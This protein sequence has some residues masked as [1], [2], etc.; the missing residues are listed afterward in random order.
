MPDIPGRFPL[1]PMQEGMI[2]DSMAW[3]SSA[4]SGH[5][6][7][8]RYLSLI[9][10]RLPR[11]CDS[12]DLRR[13]WHGLA[14]IHPALRTRFFLD[15]DGNLTQ[16]F[17]KDHLPGFRCQD[18]SG[19]SAEDQ[20]RAI[21]D[22][23]ETV[24]T[25]GIDPFA[26]PLCRLVLFDRAGGQGAGIRDMGIIFHHA[27]LDGWSLS[28]LMTQLLTQEAP[29][30]KG[31]PFSRYLRFLSKRDIQS[32]LAYWQARLKGVG[33]ACRLPGQVTG[34]ISDQGTDN[35]PSDPAHHRFSLGEST[36]LYGLARQL[37]ISPGR[38]L[39]ALWALLLCRYNGGQAVFGHVITG[40]MGTVPGVMGM[41][42]MCVNTIPARLDLPEEKAFSDWI[43]EWNTQVSTD[44][45]HGF[46][47]PTALNKIMPNY[48]DLLFV[49][50]P[51]PP[52][53]GPEWVRG[54]G[55]AVAGFTAGFELGETIQACFSYDSRKYPARAVARTASHFCNILATVIG[56]PD[57]GLKDISFFPDEEAALLLSGDPPLPEAGKTLVT[58]W[59]KAA[60]AHSERT[61]LVWGSTRMTYKELA[62]RV[63]ALA[64]ALADQGVAPDDLVAFTLN[65]SHRI[66]IAALAILQAGAAYLPL[67]P[68]WP[69][70]RIR[71]ILA[72]THPALML[73]DD[74][75]DRL[76]HVP[77]T[78][79]KEMPSPSD[80]PE[81]PAYIIMTSGTTGRPKGV[82]VE[83]RNAV[84]FCTW[85][86]DRY[87][88]GPGMSAAIQTEFA[89]DVAIWGLYPA[90]FSG[91][92]VHILEQEIRHTLHRIRDYMVRENITHM[93]LPVAMAEEF[94]DRFPGTKAPPSLRFLATG[95]DAVSRYTGV[96]YTVVNEYGPTECTV[97]CTSYTLSRDVTPIPIGRPL[98]GMQALI[99]DRMGRLAP[100]GVPGELC[101][102][103]VQV[104]RGYLGDDR[105]TTEKFTENPFFDPD[106]DGPE[107]RRLY[108]TGDLAC[109]QAA[110]D[111]D[112]GDLIFLG[113]MD[114]Q[115]KVRGFR[116]ELGEIESV[117]RSHPGID[118]AVAALWAP[119]SGS[120]KRLTAWVV[121][122]SR[123]FQKEEILAFLSEKLPSHMVPALIR[124]DALPLTPGGKIDLRALPAP[125][126]RTKDLTDAPPDTLAEKKLMAVLADLLPGIE[127]NV[128]L[129]FL[130]AGG[131]SINAI[132]LA[133]RLESLGW[134]VSLR[135]IMASPTLRTLAEKMKAS[136]ANTAK[137]KPVP[138]PNA[139]FSRAMEAAWGKGTIVLP[140]T[141]TQKMLLTQAAMSGPEAYA[142]TG[143]YRLPNT[144]PSPEEIRNRLVSALERHEI[145]RAGFA[146]D[147]DGG[148]WMVVPPRMEIPFVYHDDGRPED[149]RSRLLDRLAKMK[150]GLDP[151]KP[152][153]IRLEIFRVAQ[154]HLE[155]LLHYH[156]LILDGWSLGILFDEL[157]GIEPTKPSQI[158]CFGEY[159]Q[160]IHARISRHE[161]S[162]GF[163]DEKFPA[164]ARP[165]DLPVL[166]DQEAA[167]AEPDGS[168]LIQ[169]LPL[170]SPDE[171][172]AC[173]AAARKAGVTPAAFFMAM[174]VLV[175]K[176]Y[177]GCPEQEPMMLG[178]VSA[179]RPPLPG[180]ESLVGMCAR[181][182]PLAIPLTGDQSFTGFALAVQDEMDQVQARYDVPDT[183]AGRLPRHL[184]SFEAVGED[185]GHFPRPLSAHGSDGYDL[186][187]LF[188]D[189]G[190]D[191]A[192]GFR[193][194]SQAVPPALADRLRVQF[195][196]MA[197]RVLKTPDLPAGVIS[198]L[199]AEEIRQLTEQLG[200][201]KHLA[202]DFPTA[203]HAFRAAAKRYPDLPALARDTVCLTY[204]QLDDRT[205]ELARRL[206]AMGAARGGVVGAVM[207]RS[208]SGGAVPLGIMKAGAAYLPLAPDWPV[209]RINDMLAFTNACALVTDCLAPAD[210]PLPALILTEHFDA[211]E[212]EGE[213]PLLPEP[214]PADLAYVICT[215]GTTGRPKATAV[216]HKALANQV[217]WTL[218]RFGPCAHDQVL[219]A[220]AFSFDPSLWLLFPFWAS[221]ACVHMATGDL[222][223]DSAALMAALHRFGITHLALPTR[224]GDLLFDHAQRVSTGKDTGRSGFP[225]SLV[226][227]TVGGESPQ[228]LMPVDFEVINAYGPTEAC[229]QVATCRVSTLSGASRI[230]GRPLA[231]VQVYVV[232]AGIG[233]CPTGVA[234]ELCV[235]GPQLA[236][237]YLGMPGE[238][239]R[240]FLDNPFSDNPG[241][242]RIYRTGDRVRWLP[243][244]NLEF[245]GRTDDQVKIRGYR[246]ELEEVR[247]V[248]IDAPG[249]R[250][251]HILAQKDRA[252]QPSRLD[253]YY[254]PQDPP[255]TRDQIKAF[256]GSRLPAYMVPSSFTAVRH[257]PLNAHGKLDRN[258]LP[259]PLLET[260]S[261]TPPQTEAEKVL[262]RSW[263][264]V[265]GISD[266]CREDSFFDLGGHSLQLLKVMGHMAG[267]YF[268]EIQDFFKTPQLSDL[269]ARMRPVEA[270]V[271]HEENMR[272]YP[273]RQTGHHQNAGED[274]HYQ[275]LVAAAP[276]LSK[277]PPLP[278]HRIMITGA[279]GYLGAFLLK[280]YQDR[281]AATILVP[282]RGEKNPRDRLHAS[283]AFYFGRTEADRLLDPKRIIPVKADLSRSRDV[284]ALETC[285]PGLDMILHSAAAVNHYGNPEL[286]TAANV[287]ATEHLLA[288]AARYDHCRFA[289][290]STLSA[291][292]LPGFSELTQDAGPPARNHYSRTKQ[293]AEKRVLKARDQ[294]LDCLIFRTGNLILDT[295][296]HRFP[297]AAPSNMFLRLARMI[298]KTGMAMDGT[299]KMGP[300]FVDQAAQAICLLA[301]Q[302][303]PGP[304]IFHIDNPHQIALSRMLSMALPGEAA[305]H[306]LPVTALKA[307]LQAMGQAEPGDRGEA[308]LEYLAWIGQQ[309]REKAEGEIFGGEI[310]MDWTLALLANLGFVWPQITRELA[311]AV[312]DRALTLN[313]GLETN[314]TGERTG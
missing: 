102:S 81:N 74:T 153:L 257:W 107:H 52:A 243:D 87:Q 196:A 233:L 83:H 123:K 82:V 162:A 174:W 19:R 207:S 185:N 238:T 154:G 12:E 36:G 54:Y 310:K 119:A 225:R 218:D 236:A 206:T 124:I 30:D 151:F 219:H 293:A 184:F 116:V 306:Q 44:E 289:H 228:R 110:P 220:M 251:A 146:L 300:T 141:P 49:A 265:L 190:T 212:P 132:R 210:I 9:H 67:A 66:A 194:H 179:G 69:A 6:S 275:A 248:L 4:V 177:A 191:S 314:H 127:D 61:A 224:V 37:R 63:D 68:E 180:I 72:D 311:G 255:A 239:D 309:E 90:L 286:L 193:F 215:S 80:C 287:T 244:G 182:L 234:G 98:P 205:D 113:R 145:L 175:L 78:G 198:R 122:P 186:V 313:Q 247:Q 48:A 301:G 163:W 38:L 10:F 126:G 176:R 7:G 272:P 226:S 94:M 18:L 62:G 189:G 208:L 273:G 73:D 139:E 295:V 192:A 240:V 95:G 253:A 60:A 14:Q 91:G 294:G 64:A 129:S 274:P 120:E 50:D 8:P 304:G 282:V 266:I 25:K 200:R 158:L 271:A 136:D 118:R 41:V 155:M 108:H 188:R 262:A 303:D 22:Y 142:V 157:F 92:T 203:V 254:I 312:L 77:G 278:L 114:H 202:V 31:V 23:L 135:D 281:T 33:A 11:S 117:L 235:S 109:W 128:L 56:N 97:T 46:A 181:T 99:L 3:T 70:D 231:N 121:C 305:I 32:N 308:A 103:G 133:A 20:D 45:R 229:I 169:N 134:R 267:T 302:T 216:P 298:A 258:R 285:L 280:T 16:A 47:S 84:A 209:S 178:F 106:R 53:H 195:R 39:Q 260:V 59:R 5:K 187:I 296:N 250:D 269:A 204:R 221:G 213:A 85:A 292:N 230:I 299:G 256:M 21:G 138:L 115:V 15:G 131:D 168:D 232:D 171:F 217:A 161:T 79:K 2:F 252:G 268:I 173:K 279:T 75:F 307:Q 264:A 43:R 101:F 270:G 211:L 150:A 35:M 26:G 149:I 27:V 156:H 125:D 165:A 246:I 104:V 17:P 105:L 57:I 214:S 160:W 140:P 201:G 166:P 144:A 65:R 276:R 86:M 159:L 29:G 42:G 242:E 112:R 261:G 1:T 40:R 227:L 249:V 164:H 147:G 199:P 197:R 284:N 130:A 259:S 245:L 137:N 277:A 24:R 88:W 152:P 143:H 222:L 111:H 183:M 93:D 76:G 58:L 51:A 297:R 28:I 263:E 96:P 290:I 13:R 291:V 237:G 71:Q 34:P 283:L 172:M 148:A 241:F 100:L 170:L 55:E 89:Y 223:V 167:K 288:L